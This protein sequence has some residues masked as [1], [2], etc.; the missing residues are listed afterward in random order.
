MKSGVELDQNSTTHLNVYFV[1]ADTENCK[2]ESLVNVV[3]LVRCVVAVFNTLFPTA[4][5]I[6][7]YTS[8]LVGTSLLPSHHVQYVSAGTTMS[9][10][11]VPQA[12][13]TISPS[14]NAVFN[15]DTVKLQSEVVLL[16]ALAVIAPVNAALCKV[17]VD[18]TSDSPREISATLPVDHLPTNLE[19]HKLTS[20]ISQAV[21]ALLATITFHDVACISD[22]L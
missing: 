10:V 22:T 7:S 20:P 11:N 17:V 19:A 8:F 6:L 15:S 16:S 18:I 5:S 13:G 1:F 12:A 21:H 3:V 4:A 9:P 2:S 14:D